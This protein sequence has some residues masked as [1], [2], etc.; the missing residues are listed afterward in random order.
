MLATE[1]CL[2]ASII[3]ESGRLARQHDDDD[4]D[5]DSSSAMAIIIRALFIDAAD[6]AQT[7]MYD[8]SMLN[9]TIH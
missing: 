7:R 8:S 6:E 4:D 9:A 1:F 5:N 3:F 2:Y